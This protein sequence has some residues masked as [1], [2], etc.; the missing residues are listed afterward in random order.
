MG[1]QGGVPAQRHPGP[2]RRP[3]GLRQ[4]HQSAE[5]RRRRA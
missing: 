5:G 1:G 2:H 4:L 3:Q